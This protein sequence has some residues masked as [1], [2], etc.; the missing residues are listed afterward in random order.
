MNYNP[1]PLR[2]TLLST[3]RVRSTRT[4]RLEPLAARH[5]VVTPRPLR[6]RL[7]N[8]DRQCQWRGTL[9]AFARLNALQPWEIFAL[10]EQLE[11]SGSV[12][13]GTLDDEASRLQREGPSPSAFT[14]TVTAR[15]LS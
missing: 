6:V 15:Y 5:S 8:G 10:K 9:I 13:F 14:P 4:P 3:T 12:S 11:R 1:S 2:R 7:E